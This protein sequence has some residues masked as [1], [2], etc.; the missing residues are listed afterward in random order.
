VQVD[1]TDATPPVDV[2]LKTTT[3]DNG[4][5][6]NH[7]LLE[8]T[9]AGSAARSRT[10]PAAS[11]ST[12]HHRGGRVIGTKLTPITNAD[13]SLGTVAGHAR[14]WGRSGAD[15]GADDSPPSIDGTVTNSASSR[16]PLAATPSTNAAITNN[17]PA[18]WRLDRL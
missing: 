3:I 7:G 5:V 2:E 10:W 8:A 18:S 6:T 14:C 12:T 17:T 11:S 1:R 4:T 15:P 13:Q 9:Q 16:R